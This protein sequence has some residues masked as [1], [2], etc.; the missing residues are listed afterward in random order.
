MLGSSIGPFNSYE[1]S[2]SLEGNALIMNFNMLQ[3]GPVTLY[4]QVASILRDRIVS[5]SW[6]NG[7]DIPTLDD[8]AKQLSVARVTVRQAVQLL[9]SEGLLSSKRGRR[10]FV[11]YALSDRTPLFSSVGSVD[12]DS[13]DYD[14]AIL[15]KEK[16]SEL[17]PRQISTGVP[18]K[19]Y[20]RI[21]KIDSQAGVPYAVSENYIASA[22]ARRFPKGA[23]H[24]VKI[25]RLARDYAT[26]PIERGTEII[27]VGMISY[28]EATH[29]QAPLSSP[30]AK[31]A[32]LFLGPKD[33]IIYY[34]FLVY[35]SERFRIE[36]DISSFVRR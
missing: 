7:E 36:R 21:R 8:L 13:A 5:G 18:M 22:V 34:G 16:V 9:S 17:P 11:T 3:P 29:L 12:S 15:S 1:W 25:S 24:K 28:E 31:V 30:V 35:R 20:L 32:R 2:A 27:T 33:E 14:V 4:A 19:D 6:K 23:E 10:T 26:P